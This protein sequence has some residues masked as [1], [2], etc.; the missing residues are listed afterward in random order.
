MRTPR[1]A[2]FLALAIAAG[3][4]REGLGGVAATDRERIA[5]GCDLDA[6]AATVS[7]LMR[8]RH[9][10]P[11]LL[12]D[13]GYR[14]VQARV[15]DAAR[16]SRTREEFV[17]AFAQAWRS[18][19]FSHVDLRIARGSAAETAAFLDAMRAGAG[20]TALEWR[21]DIALLTVDTMMGT[22]TA[23][24]IGAAY[25]EIVARGARALIIDLRGNPGGAFA[26]RPLVEHA[27]PAPH[28]AGLFVSRRWAAEMARDPDARDASNLRPWT[29]WSLTAFW[30]EVEHSPATR[31]TF[32]PAAPHFA[33]P[34][35][36]LAGR[37]TASAAE[38]AADA[39][40]AS[41]RALIVGER[42]AGRML[43]QKPFDL[44]CGLQLYLPVADYHSLSSGRIEGAG[45][46]PDIAVE[47]ER[48][49]DAALAR[50]AEGE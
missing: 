41:G 32:V 42:T 34:I 44:P 22:D 48:A 20:A 35:Y 3:V 45:L 13:D 26:L 29:G 8:R 33:G 30:N 27:I 37:D 5:E 46:T 40:R 43:S 21:G 12:D 31:I 28:D 49:L 47:A 1:L 38:L 39:L 23:E 11:A 14:A 2:F 7:D 50:I 10:N 4:P 6:V 15:A 24:A 25:R 36:I 19:P 17:A 9:F 16:R 18:G